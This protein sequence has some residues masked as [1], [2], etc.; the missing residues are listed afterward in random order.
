MHKIILPCAFLGIFAIGCN[1]YPVT[2]VSAVDSRPTLS[3]KGAPPD[4]I[5]FVDGINMGLVSQYNGQPRVLIV[6]PGSHE[7]TVSENN[8]TIFQQSIFVE[9]ESKEISIH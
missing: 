5:L 1:S 6:Q 2:K 8:H 3:F 4:G 7:I 9:N